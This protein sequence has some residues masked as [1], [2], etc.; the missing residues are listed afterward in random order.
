MTLVAVRRPFTPVLA[1][2]AFKRS[3]AVGARAFWHIC[4]RSPESSIMESDVESVRD[5]SACL[6]AGRRR[7]IARETDGLGLLLLLLLQC[8]RGM[9]HV[10][11]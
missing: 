11:R 10:T 9:R 2:G 7:R 3:F 8:F 5:R 1:V 6:L 4:L